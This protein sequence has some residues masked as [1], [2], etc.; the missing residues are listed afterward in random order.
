VAGETFN[1]EVWVGLSGGFGEIRVGRQDVSHAQDVDA[2]TSQFGNFGNRIISGANS[3][4]LG[5]DQKNVI[6]YISPAMGG[7]QVQLGHASPNNNGATS[8][9]VTD[10]NSV[11]ARYNLGKLALHAGWQKNDAATKVAER[12][13]QAVGAAYDFGFVSAGLH[14]TEGD[15]ST[16]A[17]VTT[18]AVQGSIR[19]PLTSSV[20]LHGV[21]A[22]IE[23]GAFAADNKGTGY[24][25]GVTKALS[26]RT[27]LYAAYTSVD[28][29]SNS[30]M[31]MPGTTAPA[32]AGLDT[33]AYTAG[34]SHSF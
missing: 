25:I 6:K 19:M 31:A 22:V 4:D 9:A 16:T 11:Y 34:I 10:Q 33:K 13:L 26:K 20:S 18:K 14:Y 30:S 8:E 5:T 27:T 15:T 24:T 2:A 23:D 32:S 7:L 3:L 28:N 17:D 21:Y 1:R 29:E 12:D